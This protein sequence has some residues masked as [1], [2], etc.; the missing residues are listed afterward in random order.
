V[1][2]KDTR[3]SWK[4]AFDCKRCNK[5]TRTDCPCYVEWIETNGQTGEQR[6]KKGCVFQILPE[7]LIANTKSSDGLH[8]ITSSLRNELIERMDTALKIKMLERKE[9]TGKKEQ[10]IGEK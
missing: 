1:E 7:L 9:N 8:N 2:I 5:D 6:I 10:D 3:R 4:H